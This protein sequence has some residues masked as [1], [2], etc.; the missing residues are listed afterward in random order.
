MQRRLVSIATL[1]ATLAATAVPSFALGL[2][3]FDFSSPREK[4]MGGGHVALADDFSVLLSNPAG[5]AGMQREISI[6]DLGI[7]AVG[8]VFDIASMMM[9]GGLD[10]T[11]I[12]D[13]LAANNNQLYTGLDLS[14]PL[15]FGFTGGGLGFGLFN[16]TGMLVDVASVTSIEVLV[17]EDLLLVG[18]YAFRL[19]LG[20]GH[21][22]SLGMNAKGYVRGLVS[23]STDILGLVALT[24]D[25][26]SVLASPFAL[27]TGVGLDAGLRWSWKSLSVGLVCHDLYSPAIVTTYSNTFDF[28]N[29]VPG[30]AVFDT[31]KRSLDFGFAWTPSLGRL[32]QVLDTLVLALDYRDILDLGSP[33]PRNPILNVGLGVET[34]FLDIVTLRAGINEALLSAGMG[35]HLGA[36]TMNICAYGAELGLDPGVR[37]YYN[38]LV[39]FA[40]KY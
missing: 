5:L 12:T 23:K 9:G 24:S 38:L 32:G 25:L 4:G 6:A 10:A 19:D 29:S 16:S 13:F 35:L 14:G 27:T 26:G 11:A 39:D 28:F 2:D 33:V 8:P 7:Q 40:F 17:Q 15:A 20:R 21:E 31:L 18:G 1:C 22:L 37:P 34:R 36:V 3:P 30:V